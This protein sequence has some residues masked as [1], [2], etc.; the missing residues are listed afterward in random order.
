M[1]FRC[2]LKIIALQRA[3]GKID[4]ARIRHM[5]DQP[6]GSAGESVGSSQFLENRAVGQ[7]SAAAQPVNQTFNAFAGFGSVLNDPIAGLPMVQRVSEL[8][9]KGNIQ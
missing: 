4:L 1:A 9:V 3:A 5:R 7:L 8:R 2:G 6:H